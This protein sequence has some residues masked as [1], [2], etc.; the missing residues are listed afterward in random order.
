MNWDFVKWVIGVLATC[1]V[2]KFVWAAFRALFSKDNVNSMM[3]GIGGGIQN[4][5]RKIGEGIK[6]KIEKKKAENYREPEVYLR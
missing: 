4:A 1:G 2:I 6:G 3:S 5:G